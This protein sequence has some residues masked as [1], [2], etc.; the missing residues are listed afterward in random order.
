MRIVPRRAAP[1]APAPYA[2]ADTAFAEAKTYLSSRE[3]RQMSESDLERELDRRGR[4]LMRKLLRSHLDQRSPGEAEG[5]VAGADGVERRER[6]LHKRAVEDDLRHGGRQPRRLRGSRSRQSASAGRVAEPAAGALL[7]GGASAGGGGG[8]VAVVRRSAVGYVRQHRRGGAE[9]SGGAVGGSRG[10]GLR[11]VLRVA[12]R[13]VGRAGT[14]GVGGRAHLRRQGGGAA[15]RG[16]ARGDAQ[17][18]GAAPPATGA[19]VSVQP[20]EA[21]REEALEADGDGGRRLFGRAVR[22]E[23]GGVP[24][25]LDAPAAGGHDGEDQESQDTGAAPP[26]GE[27]GVGEP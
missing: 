10:R 11:R 21:G 18:G 27:A 23:R 19:A 8:L 24:A 1:P 3:A 22:A 5:P 7:A 9:A 2:A 15:P 13:G 17:G 12:P 20:P 14:G 16:P 25:E 6:R 4:E 26:G